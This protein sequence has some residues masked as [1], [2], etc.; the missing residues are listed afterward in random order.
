MSEMA[1]D[2][3][4]RADAERNVAAILDAAVRVLGQRPEASV[5]DVATA[6][7]VARQ[8]VYAHF[9][10]R[11]ALLAA[12]LERVTAEAM[13]AIDAADLDDGSAVD[14]LLRLLAATW[15]TFERYP[16]LLHPAAAPPM[17]AQESYGQHMPVLERLDGL[18]RRGQDGGEFDPALSR[19]WLLA[20]VMAL[21]HAAGEEVGSGRMPAEEAATA[22]RLSVLRVLGVPG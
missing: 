10:S 15:R 8:T 18:L 21:G 20:S 5:A 13:A 22:L 12:V 3:R 6:A 14:A 19:T 4:R 9:P 1:R 16:L 7:G 11:D 17:T 2:R